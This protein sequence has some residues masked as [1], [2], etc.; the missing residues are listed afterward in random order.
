MHSPTFPD[1]AIEVTTARVTYGLGQK[2]LDAVTTGLPRWRLGS[3]IYYSERQ[4]KAAI[5]RLARFEPAS[6][7]A[8]G[9]A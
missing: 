8:Q 3:G 1:D 6:Q 5:K 2:A 7:T 4:I 9:A